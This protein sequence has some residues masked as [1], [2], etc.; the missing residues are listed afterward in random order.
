MYCNVLNLAE[1]IVFISNQAPFEIWKGQEDFNQLQRRFGVAYK[2]EKV[3]R[4]GVQ[5]SYCR[6]VYF[7][8]GAGIRGRPKQ[9]ITEFVRAEVPK[10]Y[11]DV[12]NIG[13]EISHDDLQID[14]GED[15]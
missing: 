15:D 13:C 10:A 7:S 2:F 9:D 8:S 3:V 6:P 1:Y 5:T 11:T 4:R 14:D 12:L